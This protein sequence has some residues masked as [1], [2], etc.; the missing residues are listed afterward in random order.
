MPLFYVTI[1]SMNHSIRQSFTTKSLLRFVFP[2]IVMMVLMSIYSIVDG[3]F[4]SRI[5]GS[6]ALSAVNIV[7]PIISL[8]YALGTMLATGGTAIISKY[9]G[10]HKPK[11]ARQSLSMFVAVGIV[12]SL[13]MMVLTFLFITP[14]CF[15]LGSDINLLSHCQTYLR[16]CMI[17]APACM[18]Q[19]YYQSYLVIAGKA[20][21]GLILTVVAASANMILDYV[22][23]AQLHMGV[24]GAAIA[25]G[26]G[27]CI[28]AI[29]G[30]LYFL[31]T[32]HELHF[33]R[34]VWKAHI[35][36]D[37]CI[38]G[39]SEMINQLSAAVV[40]FM[41]N[42]IM[43][44]RAGAYG[45]AAI[46]ILLYAQFLLNALYL[47][48]SIGVSPIIGYQYGAKNAQ[49]LQNVHRISM[50]FICLT[51]LVT[52]L[53]S[54]MI[55]NR[56]VS[57]FTSDAQTY[58]LA[59]QGFY[60]F[61]LNYIFSGMN[62]YTSALFTALSNGK[63]SALVSFLRTLFF[64]VLSLLVLPQLFGLFGVWI[65]VPIAEG[66]TLVVSLYVQQK[67]FLREVNREYF[68]SV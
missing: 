65:A 52:I 60:L 53:L 67:C 4:I 2:S 50:R 57:I 47:G 24:A 36:K 19:V 63:I 22:F 6:E 45:V 54:F 42:I 39:S 18:L 61:A 30:T 34:P 40:T 37:A 55:G 29:V 23:M 46:T 14:L 15:L 21:L 48:F 31:F 35:L 5:I 28:P 10:E 68:Y 27:Q 16:W 41:F 56:L 12:I 66:L 13:A 62:I 33:V 1:V 51:S 58:T 26:I 7:Y 17:F 49:Q 32:T 59:M 11:Q 43:M 38:N 8:I 25:T 20:N 44:Q 64:T 3:I 9:L